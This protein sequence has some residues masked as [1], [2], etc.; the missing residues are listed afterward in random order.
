MSPIWQA[1]RDHLYN[2]IVNAN[3]HTF[4]AERAVVGLLRLAVRLLRRE[5][6]ASQVLTSL[7][8]LMMMKPIVIHNMSR[9]VAFGLHD[10]LRTN[11][12]NIHSSQDWYTLF[13]MLEIV[14]AGANP[15]PVM[16]V[17]SGVNLGEALHDAG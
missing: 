15:P 5:E 17:C 1:V 3:E 16:Q 6:I 4:L 11:A 13:M 8:I 2:V 12:A 14:G 9:Q 10:L 7:R